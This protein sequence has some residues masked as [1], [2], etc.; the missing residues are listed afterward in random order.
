M[1]NCCLKKSL[2]IFNLGHINWRC[3]STLN[4]LES[5]KIRLKQLVSILSL[6]YRASVTEPLLQMTCYRHNEKSPIPVSS[7]PNA[8]HSCTNVWLELRWF[9]I[10]AQPSSAIVS[11]KFVNNK[12]YMNCSFNTQLKTNLLSLSIR[13]ADILLHVEFSFFILEIKLPG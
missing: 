8:L 2:L 11:L 13:D 7:D 6:C 9:K 10:L 4:N 1:W 5:S 3:I 12:S